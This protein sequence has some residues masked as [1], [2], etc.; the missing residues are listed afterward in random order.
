MRPI[1]YAAA[2]LP[3]KTIGDILMRLGIVGM[4]PGDFRTHTDEHLEA[5]SKLG[6]TGAGFHFPGH[7]SGEITPSDIQ[8]CISRFSRH[9]IDLVQF[10]I[11]YPECLF[12]PDQAIRET[13]IDK[14]KRGTQVA[15]DLSAPYCL[16]RPGSL[17]PSGSWTPHRDN[18]TPEAWHQL[19]ETLQHITPTLEQLGV[20]AVMETH[21]VSILR[22]PE[23]CRQMVETLG[24]SHM[25]LVMDYV[26]HF[27]TLQH[28]YNS[29]ERLD[30]IFTEMGAYAPVLHIKDIS[31]GKGL[32]LHIEETVPDN[33][34]LDLVHCFQQFQN[35]YPDAYGLI[36]H[37][38]VDQI[39]EANTN[40]RAIAAQAGV[41][42][43]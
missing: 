19:I 40:T 23:S 11:T 17:N 41:P 42:I 14:I 33:G 32:V 21:L 20:V 37:L 7:L 15:S 34:E 3:A 38:P 27:E 26:N 30:H 18:H 4:L 16:I 22:N 29:Q 43:V 9:N 13:V 2:Y 24:S 8:H 36:E 35:L 12:H 25:R 10:A 31:L 5:I 6:F 1:I 39:P 28:V